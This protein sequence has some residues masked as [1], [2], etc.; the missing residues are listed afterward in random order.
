M[1]GQEERS[2]QLQ[3]AFRAD[4]LPRL[5]PSSL[6]E[7]VANFILGSAER[8]KIVQSSTVI[9]RILVAQYIRNNAYAFFKIFRN[10]S[11]TRTKPFI[12]PP[13]E[14]IK[15][16]P[17]ERYLIASNDQTT[18]IYELTDTAPVLIAQLE[19]RPSTISY[20]S[21]YLLL[22]R[23]KKKNE[24]GSSPNDTLASIY[25]L[26]TATF[27]RNAEKCD[28]SHHIIVNPDET[29]F[30]FIEGSTP[31]LPET[32]DQQTR[33]I[34]Y[35]LSKKSTPDSYIFFRNQTVA[36]QRKH[37][38]DRLL[39]H[40][41]NHSPPPLA[42]FSQESTVQI[43]DEPQSDLAGNLSSALTEVLM[44][45]GLIAKEEEWIPDD[46]ADKIFH[47]KLVALSQDCRYALMKDQYL[48]PHSLALLDLLKLN[49]SHFCSIASLKKN[50]LLTLSMASIALS[51]DAS[52]ALVTSGI[53]GTEVRI[54]K[55]LSENTYT[56]SIGRKLEGWY[57]KPDLTNPTVDYIKE[58]RVFL[59]DLKS[60]DSFRLFK[61]QAIRFAG[62]SP[63]G[64]I[65]IW[66]DEFHVISRT[67]LCN[68]LSLQQL[69]KIMEWY[70]MTKHPLYIQLSE[71]ESYKL[72]VTFPLPIEIR[73]ELVCYFYRRC[74]PP[75]KSGLVIITPED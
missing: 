56:F 44:E 51:P 72:Y 4:G 50:P 12:L 23:A 1:H 38:L 61:G 36:Y 16:S 57:F 19:G 28:P 52:M 59:V 18:H 30:S 7:I 22:F 17:D 64:N 70:H 5:Q 65:L 66:A 31:L 48:P 74:K 46:S 34:L 20:D 55:E 27:V 75:P 33:E 49:S 2:L 24:D 60:G 6:K 41:G 9:E 69:E 47:P 62:F 42:S 15:T 68:L 26:Q 32:E 54:K 40:S 43:I 14:Y 11:S 63:G 58:T 10:S 13:F 73:G 21:K 3:K 53:T 8:Q 71:E 39:N 45:K 29:A 37:F 35:A 67:S 25:C